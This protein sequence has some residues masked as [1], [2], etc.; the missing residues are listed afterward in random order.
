[1]M[2]QFVIMY[3]EGGKF[4][5]QAMM[6]AAKLDCSPIPNER[7]QHAAIISCQWIRNRRVMAP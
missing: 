1:M 5:G 4:G 3:Q 2:L 7:D 6:C